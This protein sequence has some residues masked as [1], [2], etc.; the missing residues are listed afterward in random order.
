M[1]ATKGTVTK[2]V[3]CQNRKDD[4]KEEYLCDYCNEP[5]ESQ[6][7]LLERWEEYTGGDATECAAIPCLNTSNLN[8]GHVHIRGFPAENFSALYIAPLC[9]DCNHYTNTEPMM[10]N[11]EDLMPLEPL[12][13]QI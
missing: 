1:G 13:D 6:P 10:V 11:E 8:A 9:K 12:D 3:N 5:Y 7:G 4:N 2:V